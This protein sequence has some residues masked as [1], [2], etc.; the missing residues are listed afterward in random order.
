MPWSQSATVQSSTPPAQIFQPQ[1]TPLH[2]LHAEKSTYTLKPH[3]SAHP[4]NIHP[5]P[6][7]KPTRPQHLPNAHPQPLP[8]PHLKLRHP[9]LRLDA[10]RRK[11]PQHRLRRVLQQAAARADLHGPV[12][13]LLARLVRDDLVAV[14]LEHR[15]RRAPARLGV[16][17]GRHTALLREE[18]GAERRRVCLALERGAR[19][20]FEGGFPRV[21]G[22]AVGARGVDRFDGADGGVGGLGERRGGE[23]YQGEERA[24]GRRQ[25]EG[26]GQEAPI[27]G[28]LGR[29]RVGRG[30]IDEFEVQW[31]LEISGRQHGP[32]VAALAAGAQMVTCT[33]IHASP[34]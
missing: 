13:V 26:R 18:P 27:E 17:H 34:L 20:A 9:P 33:R 5:L 15:A 19:G 3:P 1:T 30:W 21:V 12:P 10:R 29:H 28:R 32:S 11:V 25:E 2:L 14:E 23:R 8:P 31:R 7:L 24:C 6:D 16:E 4:L 22:E